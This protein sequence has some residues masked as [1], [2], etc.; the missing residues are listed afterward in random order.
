MGLVEADRISAFALHAALLDPDRVFDPHAVLP[1]R[2][3][4]VDPR[5]GPLAQGQASGPQ[6]EVLR[7]DGREILFAIL[8]PGRD[9]TYYRNSGHNVDHDGARANRDTF[10]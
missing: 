3:R 6:L 7:P 2:D 8:R 4:G 1:D 10:E 9:G 5:A